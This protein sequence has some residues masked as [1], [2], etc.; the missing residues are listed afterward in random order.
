MNDFYGDNLE[1][2]YYDWPLMKRILRYLSPYRKWVALAVC[3]LLG[4]S[5]LQLAG[6]FL[7]KIV[8]DDY[9][10]VSHYE[11][12][13]KIAGIYFLVLSL[14]FCFQYFQTLLMQYTGQK[15]MMDL[16][17]QV[18]AHLHEMPF[19]F[20]DRNPIGKMITRAVNDVEVLN[21]MLTSGLILVFSDLF[22]LVGITIMLFYLDWR[23]TLIVFIIF[24][25]LGMATKS[26][27]KFARDALRK[28]RVYASGLNSFLQENLS[29]MDTVQV[30]TGEARQSE[31]F[32]K[33]NDD[34]L[35]ED[36]RS[37]HYNACYLPSIDVFS[38][39]GIGLIIWYGGSKFV[40][41]EIKL[42]VLVA[43]LQYL[44]RFF[45][46]IR[47]LA[48]KF[49][50][51][52]SAMASSERIFELLDTPAE[53]PPESPLMLDQLKGEVKFQNVWLAYKKDDYILKDVSF[54]L[55]AGE[56]LAIVGATGSGKTTIVNALCRFYDLDKGEVF[57]D[58]ML[59]RS[60]DKKA[61]RRRIAL[62]QQDPFLFSGSVLD[63]IR[64]G[65]NDID[66]KKIKDIS[67]QI[68]LDEFVESLSKKYDHPV[69]EKGASFSMGQKQLL[70][71]ARALVFDPRILILDEATSSVDTETECLIQSA[72][73]KMIAGRTAII[74]AHRLSTLQ[75]VDKVLVL[76]SGR[77]QEFGTQ[78]ELLVKKGIFYR[79]MHLQASSYNSLSG[80][81][82][83]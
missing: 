39:L 55:E 66:L 35:R 8:I 4:V 3:L 80:E 7:T 34:K 50:I 43:F 16:R 64:L 12:L 81:E 21:E 79:L 5:F 23:L 69:Q 22:T 38:S 6:P 32:E 40:Q 30:L 13:D 25:P 26:Y 59:L 72:L 44:Q 41:D 11:G 9:I 31:R 67:R 75:Y 71:F 28:N 48:E 47:D 54:C 76:K 17:Q 60:L 46:P 49:N 62:I 77:V 78:R 57:I 63:N 14:T 53:P 82:N 56:S 51:I 68:Y 70:A 27:R 74:I 65:N 29:G 61:F 24:V 20:F 33:T 15:V 36:L 73:K 37:I 58:G 42:G 18:F 83:L 2:R 10:R 1:E 52:Q 45:D 19:S